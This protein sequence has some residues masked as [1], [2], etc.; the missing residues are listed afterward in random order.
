M[1]AELVPRPCIETIEHLIEQQ[2]LCFAGERPCDQREATLAI[3]QRQHAAA[4]QS[5]QS[6]AAQQSGDPLALRARRGSERN[7]FI[8]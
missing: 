4:A 5:P 6:E 3:R 7:V 8:E 1:R 2:H